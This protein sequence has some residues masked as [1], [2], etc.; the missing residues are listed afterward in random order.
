MRNSPML[1][2][3]GVLI[4]APAFLASAPTRSNA[5]VMYVAPH[6][7]AYTV[8]PIP[9]VLRDHWMARPAWYGSY[10]RPQTSVF[11]QSSVLYPPPGADRVSWPVSRG[12]WVPKHWLI[13]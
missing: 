7:G 10:P 4:L 5:Q 1:R 6:Y 12:P 3:A 9:T 2:L 11:P 8:E 13:R